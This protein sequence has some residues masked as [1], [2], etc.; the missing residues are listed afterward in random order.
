MLTNKLWNFT[1]S[2]VLLSRFFHTNYN[3]N[4]RFHLN[5]KISNL[6]IFSWFIHLIIERV[7]KKHLQRKMKERIKASKKHMMVCRET[8]TFLLLMLLY[9]FYF[10]YSFWTL[11]ESQ[12]TQNAQNEKKENKKTHSFHELKIDLGLV[13]SDIDKYRHLI[14][15]VYV[16]GYK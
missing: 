12:S 4:I 16:E 1:C 15:L 9:F 6:Y 2:S 5:H 11:Q 8:N 7:N 10:V 13:S 14:I 3:S